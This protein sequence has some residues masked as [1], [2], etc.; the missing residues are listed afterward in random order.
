MHK[1]IPLFSPK[2]RQKQQAKPE[3]F[4]AKPEGLPV[5][6]PPGLSVR[7]TTNFSKTRNVKNISFQTALWRAVPGTGCLRLLVGAPTS[8]EVLQVKQR[9]PGRVPWGVLGKQRQLSAPGVLR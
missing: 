1:H 2:L 6:K 9:Q 8:A 5:L 3:S 7:C 4:T